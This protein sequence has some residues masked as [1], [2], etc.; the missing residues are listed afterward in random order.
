MALLPMVDGEF[1]GT[2]G[3]IRDITER[4]ER[5]RELEATSARLEALFENS[6]I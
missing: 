1:A 5:E 3:V 2:A 6:P 4:K